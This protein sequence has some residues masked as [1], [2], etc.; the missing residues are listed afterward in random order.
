MANGWA[1]WAS[2]L[3]IMWSSFEAFEAC[4]S[5]GPPTPPGPGGGLRS[6]PSGKAG[7][8]G[9]GVGPEEW[10]RG[11]TLRGRAGGSGETTFGAVL[12]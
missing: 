9:Q 4:S 3:R 8:A 12:Q 5:A 11:R 7:A 10:T 1:D 2:S 6:G